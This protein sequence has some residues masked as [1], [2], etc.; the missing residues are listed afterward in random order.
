MSLYVIST[1]PD[2]ATPGVIVY[3][4]TKSDDGH[5]PPLGARLPP[6]DVTGDPNWHGKQCARNDPIT[7]V[8]DR[9][10][11]DE[12]DG[13][14]AIDDDLHLNPAGP[15]FVHPSHGRAANVV[16]LTIVPTTANVRFHRRVRGVYAQAAIRSGVRGCEGARSMR[17]GCH[18]RQDA[19]GTRG[20][21]HDQSEQLMRA[22]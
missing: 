14:A 4:M 12:A 22:V 5:T 18:G 6:Y 8:K 3:L 20:R 17:V 1:D 13:N 2:G 9:D 19:V 16:H 7:V 10:L 21:R 11:V 15:L